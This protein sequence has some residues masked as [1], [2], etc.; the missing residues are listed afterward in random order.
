MLCVLQYI[1]K[2]L[3]CSQSQFDWHRDSDWASTD[4]ES[5]HVPYLSLWCAL[6]DANEGTHSSAV[7]VSIEGSLSAFDTTSY[8]KSVLD[9]IPLVCPE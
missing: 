5:H 4:S 8:G 1:V 7:P 3:Q 6:D 9:L 2:P